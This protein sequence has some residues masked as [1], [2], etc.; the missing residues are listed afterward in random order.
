MG[1]RRGDSSP[2]AGAGVG[3]SGS[4]FVLQEVWHASAPP[5]LSEIA[6]G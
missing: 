6:A 1:G 4:T 3:H 2:S 5:L